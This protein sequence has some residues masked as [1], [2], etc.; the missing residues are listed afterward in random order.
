MTSTPTLLIAPRYLAGPDAAGAVAVGRALHAAGWR[1]RYVQGGTCYR[2]ADGRREALFLPEGA[3]E[4]AY[5]TERSWRFAARPVPG[6]RAIWS[7]AFSASTPPELIAAFAAALAADSPTPG[8]DGPHYLLPPVA[9]QEATQALAEA[10]WIRDLGEGI[11]WYAPTMQ[12][13]V[14]GDRLTPHSADAKNW[15]F[16]ARR[17]ADTRI[18]WHAL[19]TPGTPGHLVNAL[20]AA[21]A[22]PAPVARTVL[23]DPCVGRLEVT[24]TA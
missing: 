11:D 7:A 10:G 8:A 19:A 24:R 22:D 2:T 6:G 3:C 13:A 20:C 18:L 16:A 4:G 23:P 17:L 1:E 15:L 5:D 12:A 21:M 14:A 9:P